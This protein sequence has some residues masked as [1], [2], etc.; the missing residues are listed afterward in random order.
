MTPTETIPELVVF[1]L[2]VMHLHVEP[3]YISFWCE[4]FSIDVAHLRRSTR[5]P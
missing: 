3:C 1:R 4:P 2:G 5:H